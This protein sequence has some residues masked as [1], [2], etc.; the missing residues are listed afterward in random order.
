MK[1]R[2]K[3]LFVFLTLVMIILSIFVVT[4]QYCETRYVSKPDEA[5][6]GEAAMSTSLYLGISADNDSGSIPLKVNFKPLVL[7]SIGS[8][9]YNWDFGDGTTST[10]EK[11]MHIYEKNGTYICTLKITDSDNRELSEHIYIDALPNKA[12]IVKILISKKSGYRPIKMCFDA[13]IF[14]PDGEV[15]SYEWEIK[16]PSPWF[17]SFMELKEDF[18]TKSFDKL[19]IRPGDYEVTVTVTDD[20]GNTATDF[21][22]I[23][24][25]KSQIEAIIALPAAA[26]AVTANKFGRV[27]DTLNVIIK[28]RVWDWFYNTFNS[29][30]R[31][32][33][34][35][36]ML[37][38]VE[39]FEIDWV[40][41]ET[42]TIDTKII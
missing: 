12:P 21:V 22:R 31:E 27:Q 9:E 38:I 6:L 28:I 18:H 24:I 1:E 42:K 23:K 10:D 41:D 20:A 26:L 32:I 29:S 34:T 37:W 14:D 13:D 16:K 2:N 8:I 17:L 15:V 39:V 7:N 19:F 5:K 25:K 40:P 11:P 33:A 30:G 36:L 3:I 4:I 35:K